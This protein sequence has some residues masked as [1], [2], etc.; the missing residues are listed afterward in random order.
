MKGDITMTKKDMFDYFVDCGFTQEGAAGLMGNL[1]AESALKSTNLQDTY[2]K[3]LGMTDSEYTK[4]VDAGKHDFVYDKA[5][6]GLAQWTYWSRKQNLLKYAKSKGVS[7]GDEKTQ[8]EFMVQELK[9]YK[10][11]IETLKTTHSIREAS[12]IVLTQYESPANQSESVKKLRASYGQAIFDEV[13]GKADSKEN[14]VKYKMETLKLGSRGID[15]TI[16]E[17]IMQKMGYYNGAIDDHFGSGC[18]AAC[19]KFQTDYPECGT[20]GKSDNTFGKMCWK[21]ALSLMDV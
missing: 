11:V 10:K 15:V 13:N 5:G 14:A 20:N 21:K 16:F 19:N 18:V 6:Y 12:D 2:N 8:L 7:I 3:S 17:V 1:M 9:G 4:A